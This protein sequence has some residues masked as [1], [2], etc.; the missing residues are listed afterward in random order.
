MRL[1]VPLPCAGQRLR[2]EMGAERQGCRMKGA[3][4]E[5]GVSFAFPLECKELKVLRLS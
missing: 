5:A 1:T 3:K 2:S 4:M